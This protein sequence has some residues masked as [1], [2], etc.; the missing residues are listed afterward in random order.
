MPVKKKERKKK[1][2]KHRCFYYYI[3]TTVDKLRKTIILSVGKKL[4]Y[5]IDGS[6]K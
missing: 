5:I 1:S 3:F 6:V 2:L 4:S